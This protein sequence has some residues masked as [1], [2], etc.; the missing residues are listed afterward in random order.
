MTWTRITFFWR[1]SLT[2]ATILLSS[3]RMALAATPVVALLKSC[4]TCKTRQRLKLVAEGVASMRLGDLNVP[5]QS[6]HESLGT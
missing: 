3:L 2:S 6:D 4:M 1:G 5:W